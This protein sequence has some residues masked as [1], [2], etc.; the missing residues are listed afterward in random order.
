MVWDAGV[1]WAM[2][3]RDGGTVVCQTA[4]L[5]DQPSLICRGFHLVVVYN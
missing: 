1:G 3:E 2:G 4:I 5:V